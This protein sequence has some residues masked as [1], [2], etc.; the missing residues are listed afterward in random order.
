V[1]RGAGL[2]RVRES[3][4][5]RKGAFR[6]SAERL[7]V[8]HGALTRR[9]E[10]LTRLWG[11]STRRGGAR[12]SRSSRGL[13]VPS[14]SFFV[15]FRD[16][17]VPSRGHRVPF[18]EPCVPCRG[19]RVP[20]RDFRVP[21]QGFR[22]PLPIPC[23]PPALRCDPRVRSRGASTVRHGPLPLRTIRRCRR[24]STCPVGE[25]HPGRASSRKEGGSLAGVLQ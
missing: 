20:C 19:F 11:R 16:P 1:S 4:M 25:F 18:R 23:V 9:R 2:P 24:H 15:P 12:M 10:S 7:T 6:D 22:V 8:H 17:C 13:G 14:R 5:S 21:S 3:F